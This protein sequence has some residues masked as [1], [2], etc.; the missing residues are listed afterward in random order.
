MTASASPWPTPAWAI[1]TARQQ[2]FAGANTTSA[3]ISYELV[4]STTLT[5][6][7]AIKPG[8]QFVQNPGADPSVRDSWV[9]GLR[10]E[11]VQEHSWQLSARHGTQPDGS[12]ARSKP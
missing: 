12:Y 1:R 11:I 7:L 3:E 2:A 4:Y 10:F 5:D 6:W 8:V 9:V